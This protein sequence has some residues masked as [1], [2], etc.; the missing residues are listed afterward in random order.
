ML[1]IVLWALGVLTV[2]LS[3]ASL[4]RIR[5]KS[6]KGEDVEYTRSD[7]EYIRAARTGWR[8]ALGIGVGLLV[9]PSIIGSLYSQGEGSAMVR[10][11]VTGQVTGVT[12]TAG[13]HMKAPWDS[14]SAYNIRNQKIEMFSNDGGSGVNG[15]AISAPLDGGANASVSITV[16][17][18]INPGEVER[19]Y[20]NFGTQDELL[21]NALQPSLRDIVRKKSAEYAPL[22]IKQERATLG[23]D[24]LDTLNADWSRYGVVLEEVN[25]GDISLDGS[26][27]AA[28]S[29]V[30]TA[31]QRVEQ[32]R[33][34]LE[35]AQITAETTKTEAQAAADADQIIRCGATITSDVQIINGKETT[36]K[37][38]TPKTNEE[39]ENRLNEQVL[40]TR[41]Y[42]TLQGIGAN[43]NIVVVIPEDG[44]PPILN[45]PT[46]GN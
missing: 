13:L 1:V 10:V 31:Q 34:E 3:A 30:I 44:T 4:M 6:T 27:E 19:I 12:T 8:V 32:A 9:V 36:V 20:K 2:I 22:A 37:V 40:T 24:I 28:I 5:V 39:C 42:E 11:S 29:A 21:A 7:R 41:W 25:L 35:Q 16:L 23:N 33:A 14:V 15:A 45:L 46:P 18:S 43:G 17:Y 38:V 26:T